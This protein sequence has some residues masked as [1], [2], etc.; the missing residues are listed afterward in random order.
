[1]FSKS[2]LV[3]VILAASTMTLIACQKSFNMTCNPGQKDSVCSEKKVSMNTVFGA[4]DIT[5]NSALAIPMSQD[6]GG[7]NGGLQLSFNLSGERITTRTIQL[8]VPSAGTGQGDVQTMPNEPR[9]KYA[10][11]C[12]GS[13][14][15]C[16]TMDVGLYIEVSQSE[17]KVYALRVRGSEILERVFAPVGGSIV[18]GEPSTAFTAYPSI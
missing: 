2:L 6:G 7:S 10:V 14:P 4:V 12:A 17:V 1:M 5:I 13:D 18:L 9:I 16:A 8:N 15:T 3:G 11:R